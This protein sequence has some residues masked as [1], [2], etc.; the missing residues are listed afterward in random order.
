MCLYH[1]SI[2][3]ERISAPRSR[4]TPR[5]RLGSWTIYSAYR[6]PLSRAL[7]LPEYRR[8]VFAHPDS[9]ADITKPFIQPAPIP[10]TG[11]QMHGPIRAAAVAIL[12]PIL[13]GQRRHVKR[14]AAQDAQVHDG[15]R[16]LCIRQVLQHVVTNYQVVW[17]ARCKVDD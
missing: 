7:H 12:T 11:T 17:R 2:T 15:A 6:R 3:Y 16:G 14:R 1:W 10:G 8:D 5:W 4:C 9:K 13:R